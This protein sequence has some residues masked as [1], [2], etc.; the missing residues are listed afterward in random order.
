MAST[1]RMLTVFIRACHSYLALRSVRSA[2]VL[3]SEH[4]PEFSGLMSAD[5]AAYTPIS[6]D[7]A[8]SYRDVEDGNA[9][10][11]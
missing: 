7:D 1:Y 8:A 11:L 2:L 3:A 10:P 9:H 5:R 4:H 6:D